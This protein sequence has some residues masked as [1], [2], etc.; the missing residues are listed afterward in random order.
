MD[1]HSSQ[2]KSDGIIE[3]IGEGSC[4]KTQNTVIEEAKQEEGLDHDTNSRTEEQKEMIICFASDNQEHS[5]I[6]CS[7]F[8][9]SGLDNFLKHI[10][11]KCHHSSLV[12]AAFLN[13]LTLARLNNSAQN[14][15]QI[16][17][18]PFVDFNVYAQSG[19]YYGQC[20]DGLRDGYGLLYSVANFDYPCLLECEWKEGQPIQGRRI[21]MTKED[22]WEN[23]EGQFDEQYLRSGTEALVD[24]N[25][26]MELR[27]RD[28]GKEIT[29][30]EKAN[31]SIQMVEA[32]RET[33]NFAR[34]TAKASQLIQMETTMKGNSMMVKCM[35]LANIHLK[36][37]KYEEGQ[38]DNDHQ[39]GEHKLFTKNGNL[40]FL[41]LFNTN[42]ELQKIV[43][44]L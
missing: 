26:K 10:R 16:M 35:A 41:K 25:I 36:N 44:Y 30:M 14:G 6:L 19:I 43:E 32:M 21:M 1:N 15:K 37:G 18:L 42:G 22:M 27:I 33:G 11:E 34:C 4:G 31:R 13:G 39:I 3:K 17:Q 2:L 5:E 24:M 12:D 40:L 8:T 9:E 38:H 23:Y 7:K 20:V 29:C 28:S